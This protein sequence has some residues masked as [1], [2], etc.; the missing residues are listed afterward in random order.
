LKVSPR[1][2]KTYVVQYRGEGGR[3]GRVRRLS[4][5]RH[6]SPWTTEEARAEAKRVLGDVAHGGDPMAA[7]QA[8]RKD[9]TVAELCDLYL[10]EGTA[11]KKASTIATDKG[12]IERHIKPVIGD[13]LVS[14]IK[15]N[16][17]RT[18][19]KKVAEGNLPR[20]G[21]GPVADKLG[22]KGTASRTVGLLGGIFSFANELGYRTDNPVHGVKRFPDQKNQRYL[23][24]SE[25]TRLFELLEEIEADGANPKAVKIIK[26]LALTGARRGEIE[27]LKWSEVF[28]EQGTLHFED[29]K[30]GQKSI[31]I[32]AA[33]IGLLREAE[34]ERCIDSPYVFPSERGDG[35]YVGATK[36]WRDLRT[37]FGD[38]K[39]RMHDL[40]HS[41]A[42]LAVAGGASL[43]MIGALLGHKDTATTQRYAHLSADPLRSISDQ[44][45]AKLLGTDDG[46]K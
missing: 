22:G 32:S 28:L 45:G 33:V 8:R 44:V 29:S 2:V 16:H 25:L 1:G 18:L 19:L 20:E 43:P 46:N 12:R 39:L 5:G 6:G 35:F 7:R 41:F 10:E 36:V 9:L 34:Q 31:P 30:T 3:R 27:Q 24:Q 11:T 23:T 13:L 4:I 37:K 17:V 38:E 14:D 21:V 42:S 15:A 40:R 26:L